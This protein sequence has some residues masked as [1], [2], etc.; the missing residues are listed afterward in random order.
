MVIYGNNLHEKLQGVAIS[1]DYLKHHTPF[2]DIVDDP[3]FEVDINLAVGYHEAITGGD[4]HEFVRYLTLNSGN[5]DQSTINFYV[6]KVKVNPVFE[7]AIIEMNLRWGDPEA[8][9][10]LYQK[11]FLDMLKDCLN[12]PCNLFAETSDS[13][14]RIAQQSSTKTG[15]N[16]WGVGSLSASFGNIL[17]GLDETITK[18]IPKLFSEG[19]TELVQSGKGAWTNTQ[20]ILTGKKNVAELTA[21]A[22]KGSS[23]RGSAAQ[24]KVYGYT[25]DVKSYFST[26]KAGSNVMTAIKQELGGCFDKF[27]HSFR[28]NPYTDNLST[29]KSPAVTSVDGKEGNDT[30]H[31]NAMPQTIDN[32]SRQRD[33][34]AVG[35]VDTTTTSQS[36]NNG[37]V[38]IS[39]TY[40]LLTKT[41]NTTADYSV[42]GGFI[43]RSDNTLYFES[44]AAKAGDR[45]TLQGKINI[46]PTWMIAPSRFGT[47]NNFLVKALNGNASAESIRRNEGSIPARVA[48]GYKHVI[49]DEGMTTLYK[50]EETK[51]LN[52]G[53]AIS[54]GLF[55]SFV[56]GG[57]LSNSYKK[58][59]RLN[60][61]FVAVRPRGSKGKYNIYKV[62]DYNS[63]PDFNLD[64]TIGAMKHYR[65]SIG[66]SGTGVEKNRE[67]IPNTN[68]SKCFVNFQSDVGGMEVRICQGDLDEIKESLLYADQAP[69]KEEVNPETESK[70]SNEVSES[71]NDWIVE[72]RNVDS[73]VD[74]NDPDANL[75]TGIALPPGATITG[76][77]GLLLPSLEGD[78]WD[79]TFS[80]EDQ[81]D[82]NAAAQ[83]IQS[84]PLSKKNQAIVDRFKKNNPNF[85]SP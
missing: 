5:L 16:T 30:V 78:T 42:F 51:V 32:E 77:N 1:R 48:N 62:I 72:T 6:K 19:F 84:A 82:L 61:F 13:I 80:P 23:F 83:E 40:H 66:Q 67:A 44:Y 54:Q 75:D 73:F 15:E 12:S 7:S 8:W 74:P 57:A 2:C 24:G 27:Q 47:D 71:V 56:A 79:V 81:A 11:S 29:P 28:Y 64:F 35:E 21:L 4:T 60:Q 55:N 68:W 43:D 26:A 38:A 10:D 65:E 53:V 45:S 14:G 49:S 52:D 59:Q 37:V 3:D 17:N 39:K 69:A 20:A 22:N 46:G 9:D 85:F 70:V 76:A 34:T 58:L 63:Q 31:G 41:K 50:T 18:S 33:A 25:P 36:L